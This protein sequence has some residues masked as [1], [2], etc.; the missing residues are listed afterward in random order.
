MKRL[1]RSERESE[2][3]T[4][5]DHV[6]GADGPEVRAPG[7]RSSGCNGSP[8]NER[9]LPRPRSGEWLGRVRPLSAA[10]SRGLPHTTGSTGGADSV[11]NPPPL[12]VRIPKALPARAWFPPRLPLWRSPPH[13][14][15]IERLWAA[16][17]GPDVARKSNGNEVNLRRSRWRL[18]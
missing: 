8:R 10:P 9:S 11:I 14:V 17:D 12:A 15:A 4:W 16:G 2:T 18:E 13:P 7:S 5:A 3:V 1:C 6:C